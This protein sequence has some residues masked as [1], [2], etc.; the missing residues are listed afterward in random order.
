MVYSP[1]ST[2]SRIVISDLSGRQMTLAQTAKG[3]SWNNI[4]APNKLLSSVYFVQ[5]IDCKGNSSIVK[6]AMIAK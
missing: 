5:A 1:F 2:D 4:F 3:N 6:K